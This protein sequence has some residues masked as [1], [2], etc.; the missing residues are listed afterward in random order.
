LAAAGS[1][2]WYPPLWKWDCGLVLIEIENPEEANALRTH[3]ERSGF[4]AQLVSHSMIEV[5]LDDAPNPRQEGL[6]VALHFRIWEAM[7]P[8]SSAKLLR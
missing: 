4:R 2:F 6:E 7:N 5:A 1:S 8:T 3:F